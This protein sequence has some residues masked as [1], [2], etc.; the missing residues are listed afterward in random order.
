V[1]LIRAHREYF[2]EN[3]FSTIQTDAGTYPVADSFT[4]TLTLTSSDASITITGNS[5]NDT[6]DFVVAGAAGDIFKTIAVPAGTNPVADSSTDTLT[7]TSSDASLTIT[8]TAGTDTIDFTG[9]GVSDHGGLTGL[10]DDDHTQ[11]AL[12]LGRSGGQAL[13][14]GTGS[15]DNLTLSS[16]SHG[17]KGSIIFGVADDMEWNDVDQRLRI[18]PPPL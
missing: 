12:L 6:V 9:A 17:T 8:G 16:T 5:S 1:S 15:G 14:G 18:V 11:Y 7:L 13:I 2:A 4:D 3:T 10:T